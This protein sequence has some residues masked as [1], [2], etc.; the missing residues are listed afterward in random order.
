M[1]GGRGAE[2]TA[3]AEVL[4]CPLLSRSVQHVT[5]K[6]KPPR[7]ALTIYITQADLEEYT[8]NSFTHPAASSRSPRTLRGAATAWRRA[9][10]VRWRAPSSCR[11]VTVFG[12]CL[13][14]D[15]L[16]G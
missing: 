3:C 2:V 10:R 6:C 8:T 9:T 7:L 5:R 12:E 16:L 11:T 14:W 15:H 1:A 4:A 13:W